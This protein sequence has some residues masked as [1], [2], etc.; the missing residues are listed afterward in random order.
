MDLGATRSRTEPSHRRRRDRRDDRTSRTPRPGRCR[1]PTDDEPTSRRSSSPTRARRG[2]SRP[3]AAPGPPKPVARRR[4]HLESHRTERPVD[5]SIR[6][7]RIRAVRSRSGATRG[8]G[9]RSP[10]SASPAR[11]R[12]V[13]GEDRINEPADLAALMRHHGTRPWG[14]PGDESTASQRLPPPKIGSTRRR[15]HRLHARA[16]LPGHRGIDDL[17][18]G[19]GPRPTAS[20]AWVAR[21]SPCVS[22]FVPVFPT[23]VVP[24]AL[25]EEVTWWRFEALRDR[26]ENRR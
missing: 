2:C 23:A 20:R 8:A 19:R 3:A 15:H 13:T 24:P 26:V 1:R 5:A 11:S 14:R 10:T 9:P 17:R 6:R 16:R 12:A 7:C 25:G 22:V 21:G 4:G 18:A